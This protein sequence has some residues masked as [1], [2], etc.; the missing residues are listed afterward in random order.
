MERLV[1]GLL[2]IA[3]GQAPPPGTSA[4]SIGFQAELN[5]A[6]NGPDQALFQYDCLRLIK[7]CLELIRDG[8]D[9]GRVIQTIGPSNTIEA[10]IFKRDDYDF[11]ADLIINPMSQEPTSRAVRMA[12]S[13]DLFQAGAFEDTPGAIRLRKKLGLDAD[14]A[15]NTVDIYQLHFQRLFIGQGTDHGGNGGRARLLAGTVAALATHQPVF[16][17]WGH[18]CCVF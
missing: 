17:A 11:S 7:I 8:Y 12:E 3:R 2:D 15:R 5:D 16:R 4:R 6:I 10:Q 9:D 18:V 13:M 1:D 14:E